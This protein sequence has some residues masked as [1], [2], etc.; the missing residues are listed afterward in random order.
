M[1]IEWLVEGMIEKV[2]EVK[3]ECYVALKDGKQGWCKVVLQVVLLVEKL[4]MLVEV[5]MVVKLVLTMDDLSVVMMVEWQAGVRVV[6][7]DRQMVVSMVALQVDLMCALGLVQQGDKQELIMDGSKVDLMEML[8]GAKMDQMKVENLDKP[9]VD[10]LVNVG[11][12]VGDSQVARL[13]EKSDLMLVAS[14][15]L[16]SASIEVEWLVA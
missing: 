2:D 8:W 5:R 4:E 10:W 16:K 14:K 15:A 12:L 13:V 3:V 1:R 11:L 6:K 9:M 7:M